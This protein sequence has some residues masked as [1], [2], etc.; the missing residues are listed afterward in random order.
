MSRPVTPVSS[1]SQC[2]H[3][4]DWLV[5]GPI[6]SPEPGAF[7]SD[8]QHGRADT[9][10]WSVEGESLI[11]PEEGARLRL[12]GTI[13]GAVR[14]ERLQ[15][16]RL[17]LRARFGAAS[18]VAAYAATWLNVDAP[19]TVVLM[20]VHDLGRQPAPPQVFVD[21]V[22]TGR[23]WEPFSVA[24]EAGEH[25]L[26][27]KTADGFTKGPGWT[28]EMLAGVAVAGKRGAAAALIHPSGFWRGT[29]ERPRVEIVAALANTGVVRRDSGPLRASIDG[30]EPGPEVGSP[31][32]EPGE[33]RLVTLSAPCGTS[34]EGPTVVVRLTGDGVDATAEIRVPRSPVPGTIHVLEG[35]HCDPVWVSTQARYQHTLF[36]N[37]RQVMD[38]C[39][40]DPGYRAFLHEIDYLKPFIDEHP[41]YRDRLFEYI[42]TGRIVV[43]SSYNEPNVNNC[44]GETIVRNILYGHGF[45][46]HFLGGDPGVYHAWDVFG[47]TPQLSQ[48]VA[49]SGLRGVLWC[50]HVLGFHPVFRHL[51][52]DGTLLPHIRVSY[53][54][55]SWSMDDLRH[56][57]R[58]L[59]AENR[60]YGFD[61][62]LVVDASDFHPPSGWMPGHTDEMADSL[63]EI[64]MGGAEGF[65]DS[66]DADGFAAPVTSR[67]PSQY[68]V[69]TFHS[70]SEMKL[71]N[72][73]AETALHAA[74]VWSTFAA[75]K[76]ARYPDDALDKAWRQVL[77]GQHHD[78]LT[79]TPCDVSY[80]DLM[81]GY[82]EALELANTALNAATQHLADRVEGE[83]GRRVVVFNPL[84]HD[85]GGIVNLPNGSGTVE[86]LNANG[87]V[88]PSEVDGDMLRVLVD[89]TP[90]IGYTTLDLRPTD[91]PTTAPP[92]AVPEQP[93]A[94]ENEFWRVEFDAARGGGITSILDKATGREQIDSATRVGN[95]LGA[96]RE[97][98]DRSNAS[99]EFWTTGER[100]FASESPAKVEIQRGPLGER[101]I[102]TGRLG[103][104]ASYRRTVTLRPGSR[105]IEAEVGLGDC[106]GDDDLFVVTVTPSLEG[107]LPIM[108]D[109][110]GSVVAKPGLRQ[111]DYRSTGHLR[112]SGCAIFPAQSFVDAGWSARIDFAAGTGA[113]ESSLNLGMSGLIVPQDASVVGAGE[114]LMAVLARSGITCT[115][116]FDDD[117]RLRTAPLNAAEGEGPR[118]GTLESRVDD[119]IMAAQWI[120]LDVAGANSYVRDFLKL[121]PNDA[122]ER[123]RS[124][125][126][127]RGWAIL[128][129]EDDRVEDDW[130]AIPV[131]V[132]S[133]GDQ[134]ALSH[135]V[136]YIAAQLDSTGRLALDPACDV[137]PVRSRVSDDGFALLL[138][139]NGA[140]T[141]EP[142][143]TLTTFLTHT[144]DWPASFLGREF[145]PERRSMTFRYG[146]LPH[147]GSWR[148]GGVVEAG[149]EFSAPLAVAT[150][151]GEG[152]SLPREAKLLSLNAP[153]AI[154]T[155][156]K[157]AGNPV[158]RF[159]RSP[160][161]PSRGIVVRAYDAT[162]RGNAGRLA[163]GSGIV[164]ASA[165]NLMEEVSGALD[166]VEGGVDLRFGPLSVETVKLIPAETEPA[167]SGNKPSDPSTQAPVWCRYWQ[168]NAGAHPDG[169]LPVAI[170]LD[171]VGEME[172]PGETHA[173]VRR[174]RVTMVNDYTDRSID[175]V[176]RILA[177]ARWSV[178]PTDIPYAIPPRGHLVSEITV[179]FGAAP[180]TGLLKARLEHAGRTYQDVVEVGSR[181]V[182]DFSSGMLRF[183]KDREPAWEV[184]RDGMD[185]VVT[186]SNPWYEPL[187]AE[188]TI[189]S[190]VETW[191]S[192]AGPTA[193]G[194]IAPSSRSLTVTGRSTD[195]LRFA[196]TPGDAPV[197]F[198]AWAK[199]AVNGVPYYLPVPGTTA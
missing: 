143:G 187:D 169:F 38:A 199:L 154:V 45:H 29:E 122:A 87:D 81:A 126:G 107:S 100:V 30:G 157:P 146:F 24:L 95:E 138:D 43:G 47:H 66:L 32:L 8:A 2:T 61:H 55:S 54:W 78:A 142:D 60:S 73:R 117:D 134:A 42:R 31:A 197:R 15:A 4:T 88:L 136:Q 35:F 104:L 144:S 198:W 69:G 111:F 86:A 148:D 9:V 137:R 75:L 79:G 21:A 159:E 182:P 106:R 171:P 7:I 128:V 192:A 193:L 34:C 164:S 139:A 152:G 58:P 62:H 155:A 135:A 85:R 89:A 183:D 196:V 46:R 149:A 118:D 108:E 195:T 51:S 113:P 167:E 114:D 178:L 119:Q 26:L 76:G 102:I 153:G 91:A 190:P 129:A 90:G 173:T 65:L 115:P 163:L 41:E 112:Q 53:S 19:A 105:V 83:A 151:E 185:I 39:A 170:Y 127:D 180:R 52:L 147:A 140:A 71:A 165:T 6:P 16:D 49:K 131:V 25:L 67:N 161:D 150:A 80:L 130:P 175:G 10:P 40:A 97:R 59:L 109:R 189:I 156:V 5:A 123:H 77:F 98:P 37:C 96:L 63:P 17:D 158:S 124:E 56:S 174:I 20:P 145:V 22:E 101:A 172:Y 33:V 93:C 27:V 11:Q 14:W 84:N 194:E 168:H 162:G 70:R 68:H 48:I 50:K 160:S 186:V 74:E 94:I 92:V 132:V 23:G 181:A 184:R 82:R 1:L 57:T 121:L 188:M 110:F 166:I 36:D 176:A 28:L 3:L 133:A 44:S 116:Y 125:V 191:G 177:P 12:P 13:S 72:H 64:R 18:G 103:D 141:M 179:G 99:W 120:A